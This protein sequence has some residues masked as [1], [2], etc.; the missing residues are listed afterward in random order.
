LDLTLS[1]SQEKK[2]EDGLTVLAGIAA[3]EFQSTNK[4]DQ[5]VSIL[6]QQRFADA[7]ANTFGTPV[8]SKI[9]P[10]VALRSPGASMSPGGV[11]N[12][13]MATGIGLLILDAAAKEFF[14]TE[15][16]KLD[17]LGPV[18]RGTGKGLTV[19]GIVGGFF[20]PYAAPSIKTI[21]GTPYGPSQA[22]V[23]APLQG[24]ISAIQ[25]LNR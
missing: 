5:G 4:Y 2:L 19:G 18:I 23:A 24:A 13:T 9:F 16:N 22:N 12:T 14:G 8:A 21:S 15:Y 6:S 1:S 3:W 7:I 25:A 10:K 20:D 17:G 11:F